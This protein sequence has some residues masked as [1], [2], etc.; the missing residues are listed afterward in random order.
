MKAIIYTIFLFT[1]ITG[2]AKI[3]P[4]NSLIGDKGFAAI[5]GYYP[6]G[7]SN[8]NLRV[9]CHLLYVEYLLRQ[10]NC[11]HLSKD[12]RSKRINALNLLHHY[13]MA[14]KYPKNEYHEP[15]RK[16]CFID[17][18]GTICA[19]GYLL[20]STESREVAQEVNEQY[21]YAEIYEMD[22]A[23]IESWA[24]ENGLTLEECAMIQ[25]TYDWNYTPLYQRT[26]LFSLGTSFRLDK[27]YYSKFDLSYAFNNVLKR[28][29]R[30]SINLQCI[31]LRNGNYSAALAYYKT[32]YI[33]NKIKVFGGLG[34][35]LFALNNNDGWNMVPEVGVSYQYIKKRM[36]FNTQLGYAY[37]IGLQNA[38]NYTISR[39]EISALVG[40][41]FRL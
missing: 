4:V 12:K 23:F 5:M 40:L 34:G 33:R 21:Q 6:N 25:P 13:A 30:S 8:E 11:G 16:P 10:K 38:A 20:E 7:N 24:L 9:K 3:Q 17:E 22:L 2:H 31:P 36:V 18:E 14:G 39:N 41:G 27:S 1:S 37:H 29:F 35:E 15:M 28:R 32:I 26:L 19:V